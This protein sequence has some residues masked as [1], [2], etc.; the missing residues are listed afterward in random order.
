[1]T[2]KKFSRNEEDEALFANVQKGKWV[3]VRGSVQEDTFMRDLTLNAYDVTE[4]KH[5]ARADKAEDGDKRVELHVHT[6]MS[7]MDATNSISD[8][9]G[10]ATKWHQPAIA[11]TDHAGLQAFPEAYAAAKKNDIRMLF[12]VEANLVDDGVP[13]LSLIHI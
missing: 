3:R 6:N 12:G 4:V 13:I 8:F 5:A 2:I 7:Q 11:V 10:Q 1:M 9:V